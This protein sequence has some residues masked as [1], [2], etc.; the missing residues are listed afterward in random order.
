MT[1]HSLADVQ[2]RSPNRH[3]LYI[4]H[5]G[6]N[7]QLLLRDLEHQKINGV[8]API[9]K[10]AFAPLFQPVVDRVAGNPLWINWAIC[11]DEYRQRTVNLWSTYRLFEHKGLRARMGAAIDDLSVLMLCVATARPINQF[12]LQRTTSRCAV[13]CDVHRGFWGM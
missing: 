13:R 3:E 1:R 4:Q 2:R 7:R 9:I 6:R 8:W 12:P 11:P 5:I 10:K